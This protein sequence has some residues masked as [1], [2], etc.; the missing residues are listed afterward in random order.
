MAATIE[1]S[2]AKA[3]RLGLQIGVHPKTGMTVLLKD[4][5]PSGLVSEA[6]AFIRKGDRLV[7]IN[8]TPLLN[9]ENADVDG[10]GLVDKSE[11]AKMLKDMGQKHDRKTVDTMFRKYDADQSGKLDFD[12]FREMMRVHVLEHVVERLGTEPR[13]FTLHFARGNAEDEDDRERIVVTVPAGTQKLGLHLGM[14]VAQGA[15]MCLSAPNAAGCIAPAAR[16]QGLEVRKRDRLDM[17]DGHAVL[18]FSASDKNGDGV[19]SRSELSLA[20]RSLGTAIPSE[21]AMAKLMEKFDAN[22][23]GVMDFDEYCK[24]SLYSIY[25]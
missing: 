17:I 23:D 4:P 2:I 22:G 3:G 14:D 25:R 10:D 12:E 6:N 24:V 13:P 7:S 11:L 18:S 21:K 19:I 8:D 20:L 16:A 15:L 1:V 5:T 9:F